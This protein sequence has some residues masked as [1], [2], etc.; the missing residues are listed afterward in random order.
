M[1]DIHD[2]EIGFSLKNV[3]NDSFFL[4]PAHQ[5]HPLYHAFCHL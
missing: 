4:H 5:A 1:P 2:K 3:V